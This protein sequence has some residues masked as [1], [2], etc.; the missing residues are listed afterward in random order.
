MTASDALLRRIE[1]D[2]SLAAALVRPGDFDSDATVSCTVS[3][4][5]A[6]PKR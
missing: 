4:S 3:G 2:P 5:P 6:S 1:Q